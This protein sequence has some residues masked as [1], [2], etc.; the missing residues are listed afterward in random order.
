VYNTGLGRCTAERTGRRALVNGTSL[1]A[2]RV[3]TI[4]V[5]GLPGRMSDL[6][7]ADSGLSFSG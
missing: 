2:Q 4:F 6:A 5:I 3:D 1:R 7:I